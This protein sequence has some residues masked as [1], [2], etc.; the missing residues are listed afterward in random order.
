LPDAVVNQS[1]ETGSVVAGQDIDGA[2]DPVSVAHA[3]WSAL[4]AQNPA[5]A[6]GC[7]HASYPDIVWQKVDCKIGQPR[8]HPTHVDTE[9]AHVA[10]SAP[11]ALR[12]QP[13]R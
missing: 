9:R 11:D 1:A 5:L 13:A 4:M 6:E 12:R 2:V 8:V 3:N 10:Y 7:F